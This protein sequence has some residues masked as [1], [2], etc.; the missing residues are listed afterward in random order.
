MGQLISTYSLVAISALVITGCIA[1]AAIVI[2]K[3]NGGSAPPGPSG[4]AGR[5]TL[6]SRALKNQHLSSDFILSAI[7]DG[8]VM[9]GRDKVIHLFNSAA[10]KITGW[11]SQEAV[12]LDFHNVISLVNEKGEP[13]PK[14]AHPFDKAL[15]SSSTERDSKSWLAT[16]NGKRLPISL[17]VSPIVEAKGSLTNGVVG[18]FRDITAERQEEEQRSEFISTASHEMRT[19]LAAIDGYLAL[20][21]NEK[22][23][24]VDANARKYLEKATVATQHLSVLFRDLLT[25]SKA[26]DGRLASYPA[27]VELGEIVEQVAEAGRFHAKEKGLDLRYIMST[28]NDVSGGKVIR[29]LYY[30]NV[31]P[32]RI[33]EVL[34]NIIDNAIKYTPE[35]TVTVRLTGDSSVAQ[36]Q[37]Q[38]TGPGIP[39][40]DLS[41]LFQKFYRVD[42]S[43]TR[44]V[45]GTGLGLFISKKII[46]LYSGRIWVESELGKGST[47]FINLPRLTTGQALE[48]QKKQAATISPLDS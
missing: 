17:I 34:Q 18:V 41:H 4:Q 5:A 1:A 26:E 8:V 36:I 16:K 20:A 7:E 6:S 25:S 11:P 22:I 27:V 9:V 10:S 40:E 39:T 14:D 30:T 42:N 31:D 19:P 15:A 2:R 48:M 38:D 37:I 12:G 13:Y 21:L 43:M 47:F 46:E 3:T 44:S 29:P 32:N 28:D 23:S 33:R 45:G 24:K 35:G